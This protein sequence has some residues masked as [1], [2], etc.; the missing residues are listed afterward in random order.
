MFWQPVQTDPTL[1]QKKCSG[2]SDF[3]E[4][5]MPI[6]LKADCQLK[7]ENKDKKILRYSINVYAWDGKKDLVEPT[8]S[9]SLIKFGTAFS[10]R[11]IKL[12]FKQMNCEGKVDKLCKP[13]CDGQLVSDAV[14]RKSFP[15]EKFFKHFVI[16]PFY[17]Y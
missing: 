11:S 1:I 3:T 17:Y 7:F 8:M 14:Y 6:L 5:Q 13:K 2:D 15:V 4:F 16:P 12:T 9:L 10:A